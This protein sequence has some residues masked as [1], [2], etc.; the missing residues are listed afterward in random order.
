MNG[1]TQIICAFRLERAARSL[2]RTN[3]HRLHNTSSL[4]S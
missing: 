4:A 1:R 2:R 3:G